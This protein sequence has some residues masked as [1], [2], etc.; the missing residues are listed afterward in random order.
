[1][2]RFR[3]LVAYDGTDFHGWQRQEPPNLPPLRT[4]QGVLTDAVSDLM[5]E[6]ITVDGASRT[7][8]GVHA[9]GQIA[10]FS[11]AEPR[12]PVDR[13]AMALNTRLPADIEVRGVWR[14][15]DSFDP[16]R[17]CRSKNYFYRLR[18][19]C[20]GRPAGLDG[21]ADPFERRTT[22]RCRHPLDAAR[23]KTAAALMVGTHDYR[24]FA[25][26]PE[27][28]ESTVRT[29]HTCTVIEPAPGIVRID[30]SGS[31]FLYHMV[32][33]MVGTLVEVGRGRFEPESIVDI[34]AACDRGRAGPTMSPVGLCLEWI[35]YDPVESAV[36]AES[37]D[38]SAEQSP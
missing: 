25:H 21:R 35:H 3:L 37:L 20:D 7:D 2:P 1:M 29:I 33:I 8:S 27:Q 9:L 6:R 11:I 14:V 4:A 26:C 13:I 15:A 31:G 24:S 16:I 23:M 34:L 38:Q 30:V 12:I 28:R 36:C 17:N 22:A 32:R 10:A 5:R 19:G 18:H